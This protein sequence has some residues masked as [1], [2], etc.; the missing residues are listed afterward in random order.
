MGGGPG[1]MA[2]C[3]FSLGF[4]LGIGVV[5]KGM[6][7]RTRGGGCRGLGMLLGESAAWCGFHVSR[8]VLFIEA[9]I[10]YIFAFNPTVFEIQF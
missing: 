6:G 1:G 3:F 7:E 9:F 4:D 8:R 5:W 10:K 2:F